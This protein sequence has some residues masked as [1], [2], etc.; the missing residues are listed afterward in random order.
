M[1]VD[2]IVYG[3]RFYYDAVG[4]ITSVYEGYTR[5]GNSSPLTMNGYT[6]DSLN[7]LKQEVMCF[8]LSS[9]TGIYYNYT[10]DFTY[11][12]GGNITKITEKD[13]RQGNA[14]VAEKTLTYGNGTWRDQLTKVTKGTTVHA[15]V[16]D[17]MGNPTTYGNG[18]KLY[19]NLTWHHGRQLTALTT[20]NKTYTYAYDAEGI[21]TS[22]IVD[23]V[24]HTYITQ[25]GKVVREIIRSAD[26]PRVLDFIYNN[27]GYSLSLALPY[28]REAYEYNSK[29]PKIVFNLAYSHH[30][31]GDWKNASKFYKEALALNP[32]FAEFYFHY[33]RFLEEAGY[34]NHAVQML[35]R[36]LEY[37][38]SFLCDI[39]KN[40]IKAYLRQQQ[41]TEIE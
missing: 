32:D 4:N 31:T 8:P 2:D 7:Q 18:D 29:S 36:A 25:N 27:S 30:V 23:G 38:P 35:K 16:Y 41:A 40:E 17:A 20:G 34:H 6:Y 26:W 39:T 37:S 1:T 10:Y 12:G 3:E 5:T 15:L 9:G 21:R 13:S 19:T 28:N 22:K 11:D 33:G 24:T 14:V